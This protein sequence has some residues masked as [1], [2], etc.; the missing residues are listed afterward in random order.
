MPVLGRIGPLSSGV[1]TRKLP[2]PTIEEIRRACDH[3]ERKCSGR[4]HD[5]VAAARCVRWI[6][7][8]YGRIIPGC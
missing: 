7:E 4:Y 2:A 3:Y 5:N 6:D 1:S 8:I